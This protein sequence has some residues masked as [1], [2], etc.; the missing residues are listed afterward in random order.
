[1]CVGRV[2]LMLALG[3]ALTTPARAGLL[4]SDS[5]EPIG[6][7]HVEFGLNGIYTIDKARNGGVTAKCHSTD[8][9]ITVTSGIVKGMDISLTL[10]YT[11]AA[12]Q[13]VPGGVSS[14]VDGLND[15]TVDLKYRLWEYAGLKLAIK[16]G[17]IFPTGT[18]SEGLSDGRTGF[19]TALLATKEFAD[20]KVSLH[21]NGGYERHNYGNSELDAASRSDIFSFSV[22][23]EGEV[24][25]GLKLAADCGLATDSARNSATPVVYA[26]VGGVYE[27][28]KNMDIYSGVRAGL[29]RHE[30]DFSA[31][32]GL[33]LK[34]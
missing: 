34:F 32:Y 28:A 19:S 21:A 25:E 8:S 30:D 13:K 27:L 17:V 1:M 2:A 18:E 26:L 4:A 22:A 24:A 33:I 16:P 15:L 7:R 11:F 3:A 29:T 9:D 5:A 20:G 23:A 31:L 10:P 12:R 6:V 14:R